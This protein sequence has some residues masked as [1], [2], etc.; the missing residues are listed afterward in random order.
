ML[1]TSEAM[2]RSKRHHCSLHRLTYIIPTQLWFDS[3]NAVTGVAGLRRP[4]T[5]QCRDLFE[6]VLLD[7][8]AEPIV[9]TLLDELPDERP[10]VSRLSGRGLKL[11]LVCQVVC[12]DPVP[13]VATVSTV[14]VIST[15]VVVSL[16]VGILSYVLHK[17]LT[18]RTMVWSWSVKQ[19][20]QTAGCSGLLCT[21]HGGSELFKGI[22]DNLLAGFHIDKTGLE[23][24]D[25]LDSLLAGFHLQ[26]T[27][28]ELLD[29]L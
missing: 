8:G 28:A 2:K 13:A 10:M 24:F 11:G 4:S 7:P 17:R 5:D 16:V 26:K 18:R 25:I 21:F 29:V 23:V 19:S 27:G 12:Y 22:L 3:D 20:G 15:V 9:P 1:T 6:E 14:V